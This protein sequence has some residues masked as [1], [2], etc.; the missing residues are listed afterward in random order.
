MSIINRNY[1]LKTN[2]TNI[3]TILIAKNTGAYRRKC[4]IVDLMV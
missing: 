4:F 2:I 1:G 3:Y